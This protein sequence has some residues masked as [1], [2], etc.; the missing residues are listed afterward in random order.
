MIPFIRKHFGKIQYPIIWSLIMAVLLCLPGAMLP[1]E[2]KFSIPQFDKFVHA[3][4]FGGFVFLWNLYLSGRAL[5][6]VHAVPTARLLRSF[7]FIY[8][9]G[10]IY[11]IGSELLQGCCIPLRDFDLADIIADMSGAGL[12]YGLSHL[13]LLPGEKK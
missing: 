12:A 9:L 4:M 6:R 5:N 7:F 2:S 11:G 8:L 10:N 3:G 1:S 13:F